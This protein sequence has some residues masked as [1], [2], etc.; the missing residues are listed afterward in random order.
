MKPEALFV[1]TSRAE[2][3][4]EGALAGALT[5]GRPGMAAVDVYEEEPVLG[6]AHPL[7]GLQNAI[8][9]PHLGYVEQDGYELY[10][11]TAFDNLA[12][13]AAAG[14]KAGSRAESVG[15]VKD[16]LKKP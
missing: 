5:A 1:N 8:C 9:T 14:S 2:L 3:V 15:S 6:A 4:A 16:S 11:G 7:L 13:F 10:F 12:A